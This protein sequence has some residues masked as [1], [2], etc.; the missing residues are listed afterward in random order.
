MKKYI[1]IVLIFA[2]FGLSNAQSCLPEGIYFTTQSQIDSFPINFPG[3]NW[4]EGDII[5]NSSAR[6]EITNLLG[7]SGLTRV[8]GSLLIFSNDSLTSL[9]GLNNL[10]MIGNEFMV[11][12]NYQLVNLSGLEGLMSIGGYTSIIR[13]FFLIDF[14]GLGN[15]SSVGYSVNITENRNLV[16]L[17]GLGQLDSIPGYL[18]IVEN[19]KLTDISN[20]NGLVYTQGLLIKD[21]DSL[22]NL[23]GLNSLLH[24]GDDLE[25]SRSLALQS[26]EGLNSLQ[27]VDGD[28]ILHGLHAISDMSGLSSLKVIGGELE[29]GN[30]F[31]GGNSFLS[32]DGLDSLKTIG[33]DLTIYGNYRLVNIQGIANIDHESIGILK[34]LANNN[35]E[36]CHVKSVCD[37]LTSGAY[38][39]IVNNAVGCNND[40]EVINSCETVGLENTN[41]LNYISIWPN[42]SKSGFWLRLPEQ[43]LGCAIIYDLS[44]T[45][46]LRIQLIESTQWINSEK[47]QPGFYIIKVENE[48]V[49]FFSKLT[50]SQ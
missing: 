2:K 4:I 24:I 48:S 43:Q 25:I 23:S 1:L 34:I 11:L 16:S 10:S 31:N 26:F 50:I 49:A 29:I 3:C 38:S 35:L 33:G 14:T 39:Q 21:N 27:A 5:I 46:I 13:N 15:L 22:N 17:N 20:F 12:S 30:S 36:E 19:E 40:D 6:S 41:Y 18:M 32:F 42:P 28:V 9:D 8:D 44:A 47:L 37:Y 45:E 7:L